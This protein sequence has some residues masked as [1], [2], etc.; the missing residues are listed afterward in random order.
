MLKV[1]MPFE[2]FLECVYIM[3]IEQLKFKRYGITERQAVLFC[4]CME[5]GQR[6]ECTLTIIK[7]RFAHGVPPYS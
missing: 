7:H 4:V 5:K 3:H 1:V 2:F 6:T